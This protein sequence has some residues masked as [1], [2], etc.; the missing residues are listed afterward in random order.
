MNSSRL[1]FCIW[2]GCDCNCRRHWH[3]LT[4]RRNCSRSLSRFQKFW[5]YMSKATFINHMDTILGFSLH[6]RPFFDNILSVFWMILSFNN[7]EHFW[8]HLTSFW[9]S[10]CSYGLW[11]LSKVDD[12]RHFRRLFWLLRHHHHLLCPQNQANPWYFPM[13]TFCVSL[14]RQQLGDWCVQARVWSEIGPVFGWWTWQDLVW[15]LQYHEASEKWT[16]IKI[17]VFFPFPNDFWPLTGVDLNFLA[18][19][20][21][22]DEEIATEFTFP[23][24]PGISW[25]AI[26]GVKVDKFESW[27][28]AE[29]GVIG[30]LLTNF[31]MSPGPQKIES[32]LSKVAWESVGNLKVKFKNFEPFLTM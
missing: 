4:G 27:V 30:G 8:P 22:A 20:K 6:F 21:S 29:D 1:A 18:E 19:P 13:T 24:T 17:L 25:E 5:S 11:T 14:H 9:P 16:M 23:W 7:F 10:C 26:A 28:E 2:S 12:F 3:I 32:L 31:T 15:C